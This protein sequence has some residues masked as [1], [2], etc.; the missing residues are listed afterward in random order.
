MCHHDRSMHQASDAQ[1]DFTAHSWLALLCLQLQELRLL[2]TCYAANIGKRAYLHAIQP[3]YMHHGI[4][5]F[6]RW[7]RPSEAVNAT[8]ANS[9]LDMSPTESASKTEVQTFSNEAPAIAII[10]ELSKCWLLV[11]TRGIRG[12]LS[13]NYDDNWKDSGCKG[14]SFLKEMALRESKQF[15]KWCIRI[16]SYYDMDD[17]STKVAGNKDWL[18]IQ[19]WC[20]EAQQKQLLQSIVISNYIIT[21]ALIFRQMSWQLARGVMVHSFLE[22]L[23]K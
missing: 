4:L 15:L 6:K 19:Q 1:S 22:V 23:S 20:C 17:P 5:L 21:A 8:R 11:G 7:W 14:E 10:T 18:L 3:D 12:T 13:G 9:I 2:R 16:I